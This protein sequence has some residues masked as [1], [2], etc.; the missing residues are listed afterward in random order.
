MTDVSQVVQTS[1]TT[2]DN[3]PSQDYTHP[4]DQTTL[5]H[6]TP[7]FKP[8]T[9]MELPFFFPLSEWI[10]SRNWTYQWSH[11]SGNRQDITT[12]A[13]QSPVTN[14]SGLEWVAQNLSHLKTPQVLSEL[15]HQTVLFC[16]IG[17]TGK[18]NSKHVHNFFSRVMFWYFTSNVLALTH[19]ISSLLWK[20][21]GGGRWQYL[22]ATIWDKTQ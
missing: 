14:T 3:S 1:V 17:C 4:D 22:W 9:V 2:T 6:V 12:T 8:F 7:G 10:L 18:Q 19:V 16:T 21:G 20:G 11:S 13:Q 5:L 15:F